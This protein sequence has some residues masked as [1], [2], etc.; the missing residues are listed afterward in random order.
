MILH[1]SLST[2][3]TPFKINVDKAILDDLHQ[4]LVNTRWADSVADDWQ[5][6]AAPTA[7]YELIKKWADVYDWKLT[8]NR[9][10]K[11]DHFKLGGIHFVRSGTIGKPVLLLIHGWPD[12]FMRFEKIIPMLE[13]DFD[14]IISEHTGIWL[15]RP[16]H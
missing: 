4:R 3:L 15:L 2:A 7:L 14:L 6:G 1:M 12:S 9:L 5:R 10:N 16:S 8:E 11:L 13:N